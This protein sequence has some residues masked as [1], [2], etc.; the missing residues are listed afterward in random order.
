M[1][2]GVTL[3]RVSMSIIYVKNQFNHSDFF[4]AQNIGLGEQL[5]EHFLINSMFE[6]VLFS[7]IGPYFC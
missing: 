6:I 5:A 7:K 4:P 3:V 2:A 1:M